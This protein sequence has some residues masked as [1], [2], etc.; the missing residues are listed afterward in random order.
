MF[1]F[2]SSSAWES[3]R[4][5]L[6]GWHGP[7][8]QENQED[9]RLAISD[10]KATAPNLTGLRELH[11]RHVHHKLAHFVLVPQPAHC[12]LAASWSEAFRSRGMSVDGWVSKTTIS[13]NSSS[14][15]ICWNELGREPLGEHA[16]N[17]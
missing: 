14:V 12:R 9:K 8:D 5:S 4:L 13:P 7:Y 1:K 2:K 16:M 6:Q 3:D 10:A 17:T 15:G 11:V